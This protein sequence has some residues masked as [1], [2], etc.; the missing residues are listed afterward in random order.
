MHKICKFLLEIN[1]RKILSNIVI[2][3][4]A[5]THCKMCENKANVCFNLTYS[6]TSHLHVFISLSI[7]YLH[8]ICNYYGNYNIRN[9]IKV[10][11]YKQLPPNC[12]Y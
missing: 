8:V 2:V 6:Y 4:K 10:D 5:T 1:F 7:D 9:Y 11:F 3:I 12:V